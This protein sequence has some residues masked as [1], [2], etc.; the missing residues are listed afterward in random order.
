MNDRPMEF[1]GYSYNPITGM[2][3]QPTYSNVPG[4]HIDAYGNYNT[5]PDVSYGAPDRGGF[6][7]G[8]EPTLPPPVYNAPPVTAPSYTPSIE[9]V[10]GKP[11]Y[12]DAGGN[13]VR[14]QGY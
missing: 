14:F 4:A 13:L 1:I 7:E 6:G 8:P 10:S 12:R 11:Y 2:M 3:T 9:W 5:N